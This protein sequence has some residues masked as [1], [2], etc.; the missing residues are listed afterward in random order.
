MLTPEQIVLRKNGI[1]GSDIAAVCGLDKFRAPIDVWVDKTTPP[2]EH[3]ELTTPD[4]YRGT[5][6]EDGIRQWYSKLTGHKVEKSGV[7]FHPEYKFI[8]AS[9]DGIIKQSHVLEIKSPRRGDDWGEEFTDDIPECYIPQVTWECA[10]AQLPRADVAALIFGELKQYHVA[11]DEDLFKSLAKIAEHFWQE[12]VVENVPPPAD[13]TKQ[14]ETYLRGKF[15]SHTEEMLAANGDLEEAALE[16][17]KLEQEIA[18]LE[19]QAQA[20]KNIIQGYIGEAAGVE[21]PWG[22]I[23][24]KR[25]KDSSAID[26]KAI[27][28][29]L[30]PSKEILAKHTTVKLGSRRFLKKFI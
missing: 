21:G 10:C 5:Y 12:Y 15:S 30:S 24:W 7:L 17:K 25:S 8:F 16:L 19:N 14:Y 18:D 4:I 1:G 3:V 6:L 23:T 9:P 20:R 29:E 28:A 2:D 26:Y 11:Y 13:D 22:K 27:V